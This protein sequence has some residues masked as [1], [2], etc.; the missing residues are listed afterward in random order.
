M[1]LRDLL[2]EVKVPYLKTEK[3]A[4]E[5]IKRLKPNDK[6]SDDVT[7]METGKVFMKKGDSKKDL[8]DAIV[9][10]F[11]GK[12]SNENDMKKFYKIK[13][14]PFDKNMS[15]SEKK[16]YEKAEA[17][18]YAKVPLEIERKDGKPF[19]KND[20]KVLEDYGKWWTKELAHF[21]FRGWEFFGSFKNN[22]VAHGSPIFY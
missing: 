11:K 13:I 20:Q 5:F 7:A 15:A 1:K 18:L 2:L 14:E 12:A 9:K 6:V 21:G 8:K 17:D 4:R 22:K 10:E 16:S 19:T 3:Q